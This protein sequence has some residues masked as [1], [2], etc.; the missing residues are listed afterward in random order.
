MPAFLANFGN[1]S[2]LQRRLNSRNACGLSRPNL[3]LNLNGTNAGRAGG[4]RWFE[5]KLQRLLQILEGFFFGL[6]LAGNIDFEAS[7]DMPASISPNSG[8]EWT[9]DDRIVSQD[10]ALNFG[11]RR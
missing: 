6:A 10:T 7:C 5:V 11:L 2:G 1:C 8:C 3:N 4:L 9:F